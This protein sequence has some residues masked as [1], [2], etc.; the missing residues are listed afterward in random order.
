MIAYVKANPDLF[1]ELVKASLNVED[2]KAWRYSLLIG[3]LIKKND[4]RIQPLVDEFVEVLNQT[5]I[6]GH[7]RQ[8]LV[9]LDKMKLDDDQEGRLF[10]YCMTIWEAINKI[11]STRM[12]AFWMMEKISEN[13]PE[14]KQELKYFVTSYYTETLSPGI[15]HHIIKKYGTR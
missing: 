15:K 14:L 2:D 6:D 11:P 3:H 5:K 12:R 10:N 13:Y 4:V 7:Q 9:V 1:P 8:I